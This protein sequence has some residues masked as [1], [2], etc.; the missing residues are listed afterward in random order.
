MIDMSKS[1]EN[2]NLVYVI[3]FMLESFQKI[4]KQ[5]LWRQNMKKMFLLQ[6]FFITIF[7][8]GCSRV[9]WDFTGS[10]EILQIKVGNNGEV[11]VAFVS[12]ETVNVYSFEKL[13]KSF[14]RKSVFIATISNVFGGFYKVS[15]FGFLNDGRIFLLGYKPTLGWLVKVGNRE[16]G[17]YSYVSEFASS[18]SG[19]R[20]GF[21]Y[22]VGGDFDGTNIVGGKYYVNVDGR[23]YGPYDYAEKLLFSESEDTFTFVFRNGQEYFL[24]VNDYE[25]NCYDEVITPRRIFSQMDLRFVYR[26][27]KIWY[28]HPNEKIPLNINQKV[29]D[30]VPNDNGYTLVISES[31]ST[32]ITNSYTNFRIDGIIL[33]IIKN[34]KYLILYQYKEGKKLIFDKEYGPFDG[35]SKYI[36]MNSNLIFEFKSNNS[37]YISVPKKIYGPFKLADFYLTTNKISIF[38]IEDK[39][40]KTINED[41]N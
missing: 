8:I 9:N 27:K 17:Y 39:R 11:A 10:E 34:D 15:D 30:I 29:H 14:Q 19:K 21:I 31:N 33:D 22:N 20:F 13:T 35:V 7:I 23:D 18:K 3:C 37:W 6:L 40:I 4:V 2:Q 38:Y 32:I 1:F 28:I 25:Y 5:K 41:L 24:K 16:Y 12:N 36:V 26:I